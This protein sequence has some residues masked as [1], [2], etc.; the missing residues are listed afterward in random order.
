MATRILVVDDEPDLESMITQKFRK[1][2]REKMLEFYFAAT[3]LAA[4]NKLQEDESIDVVL[5]DINM[6]E[7]DGLTLL[8]KIH[9]QF[10]LIKSVI[11]SA[12]GDMKNIRTALNRG[13]FDF[14]TKPLEFD[15]LEITLTKT[16]H[17]AQARRQAVHD[18]DRL[19]ALQRE[20]DVARRIQQS[21]LPRTFPTGAEYELHARMLT[22]KE[23]GGDLYDFFP[24]GENRLGFVI[25]D[26]S[27]KGIPAA[28]FMAVSRTLLRATAMQGFA[29]HECLRQVNAILHANSD[30][31]TF[32]TI[33]YG[34]LDTATGAV[35]F[36]N[37]AHNPPYVL[38]AEGRL[39]STGAPDGLMLGLFPQAQYQLNQMTLRPGDTLVLYTDGVTEAKNPADEDYTE[40][41]LETCLP[42]VT[43][44]ALPEMI[45][46]IIADVNHFVEGAPQADDLTILALRYRG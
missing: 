9:E 34:I 35:S 45:E 36:C 10:P 14:I 32:V 23:V 1:Q 20:L 29:P 13:A 19:V 42:Q 21:I 41:R 24:L 5:T 33:F 22:A 30:S 27:G 46:K 17:E 2:V 31:E 16:I 28:F 6:P 18:R 37:G 40:A 12:Y 26:A 44:F 38:R 25:G 3:G 8:S 7:M 39:E 11:V 15:D 4:L 43:R